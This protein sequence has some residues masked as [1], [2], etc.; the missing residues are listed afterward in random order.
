MRIF[1]ANYLAYMV[2]YGTDGANAAFQLFM[3]HSPY[4]LTLGEATVIFVANIVL[5][6]LFFGAVLLFLS[7]KIKSAFGVMAFAGAWLFA[8]T[9]LWLDILLQVELLHILSRPT[10]NAIPFAVTAFAGLPY[11]IFGVVIL[12]FVFEPIFAVIAAIIIF[13]FAGRAFKYADD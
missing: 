3:P 7:A 9:F 11:E 5:R 8:S 12:P 1:T 4:L 2:I 10:I 6:L 13:P